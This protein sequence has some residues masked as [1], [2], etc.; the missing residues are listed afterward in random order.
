MG[1]EESIIARAD[2]LCGGQA[3]GLEAALEAAQHSRAALENERLDTAETKKALEEERKHLAVVRR[4]LEDEGQRLV[5]AAHNE[6]IEAARAAQT[7]IARVVHQLQ[8]NPDS[9]AAN[10]HRVSVR[11]IENQLTEQAEVARA[12]LMTAAKD[13]GPPAHIQTGMAV[14]VLSMNADGIVESVHGKKITV[15]L[16]GLRTTVARSDIRARTLPNPEGETGHFN[17]R[18]PHSVAASS[19]RD[20]DELPPRTTGN[21]VDLRGL[22]VEDAIVQVERFLDQGVLRGWTVAFLLHGHGTGKLKAGL[23]AWLPTSQYVEKFEA[24]KRSHGGDGVTVVWIQ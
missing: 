15:D 1:L 21:T 10:K 4:R 13:P 17:A 23:R 5:L 9:K 3:L 2:A 11:E 24:A 7:E 6:A 22:H 18:R 19:I 16:G 14:R 12:N 20:E 8:Q